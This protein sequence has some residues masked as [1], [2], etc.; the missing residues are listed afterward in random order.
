M[1]MNCILNVDFCTKSSE[2]SLHLL[3]ISSILLLWWLKKHTFFS[4]KYILLWSALPLCSRFSA[5]Y[6]KLGRKLWLKPAVKYYVDSL[7]WDTKKSSSAERK[8]IFIMMKIL[9]NCSST[10]NIDGVSSSSSSSSVSVFIVPSFH[11]YLL[12]TDYV[13]LC[14]M[15][16][17][18]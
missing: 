10:L 18:K 12:R 14:T 5:Y 11:L 15:T 1:A 7:T 8:F 16:V 13:I 2:Q 9:L 3:V 6:N 17:I 4:F